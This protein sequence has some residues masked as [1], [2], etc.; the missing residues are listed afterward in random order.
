MTRARVTAVGALLSLA[1]AAAVF[2]Q[3][4][5]QAGSFFQITTVTVK[6]SGALDY[7]EYLKKSAAA[8]EK[9]AIQTPSRVS[10]YSVR[11]GG[12]G[13]TYQI[14]S[15]FEKWAD[16]DSWMPPQE[17]LTKAYGELEATK[18]V[19]LG[20]SAVES[21]RSEVFRSQPQLSTNPN[22]MTPPFPFASIARVEIDPAMGQAYQMA[23]S[24]IKTATEKAGNFPPAIRFTA[25]HGTTPTYMTATPFRKFAERDT[26]TNLPEALEKEFGEAE[27]RWVLDTL[28]KAN[29][30]RE[31]YVIAYRPELSWMRKSSTTNP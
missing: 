21:Q 30:H 17:I 5:M 4:Q 31:S 29:R 6:A 1:V 28:A 9:L 10:V 16:V 2:A 22:A 11:M 19:K 8:R 14:V 7:E 13:Y 27:A 26:T 18:I 12:T 25:V 15:P 23:L 20:R 3:T 24:K